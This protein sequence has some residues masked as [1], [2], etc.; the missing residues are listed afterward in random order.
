VPPGSISKGEA[1]ATTGGGKTVAC[2][3]CHGEGLEGLSEIPSIAGREPMYLVRQLTDIKNGNRVGTWTVLMNQVVAKLDGDDIIALAARSIAPAIVR[4]LGQA[5]WITRLVR[6]TVA[7]RFG[8]L[9]AGE[10]P[11]ELLFLAASAA[12]ISRKV[13]VVD[14]PR[15]LVVTPRND[16]LHPLP[17]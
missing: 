5:S 17:C 1:L 14:T 15:S 13:A 16:L 9:P 10:I 8:P 3:I 4:K 6:R 7:T 11:I 2:A 12:G